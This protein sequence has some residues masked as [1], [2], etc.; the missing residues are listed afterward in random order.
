MFLG[1]LN[2]HSGNKYQND[3]NESDSPNPTKIRKLCEYVPKWKHANP[4][5]TK[6]RVRNV[7]MNISGS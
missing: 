3:D 7:L 6:L 2:I 1:T 4:K 5:Y